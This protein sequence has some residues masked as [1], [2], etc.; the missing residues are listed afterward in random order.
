MTIKEFL[1]KLV[2]VLDVIVPFIIGLAVVVIVWGIFLYLTKAGEEEKRLEARRYILFGI[3]GVFFMLSIWG[4]VNIL[5]DTFDLTRQID[6]QDIP[7][8]PPLAR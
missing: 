3:I 8:V 6:P 4:F 1:Q 2:D 7:K 5:D